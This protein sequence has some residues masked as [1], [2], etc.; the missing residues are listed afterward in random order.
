[1]PHQDQGRSVGAPAVQAALDWLV[2][3]GMFGGLSFRK[4]CRWKPEALVQAA[5]VWAWSEETSL[6]DRFFT[7]QQVIAPS[8]GEQ[9]E[10][11]SYQAFVKLL[12]RHAARLLRALI[13]ALQRQMQ[14]KLSDHYR[15]AGYLAF[16]VD[17]TRIDVPRTAANEQAFAAARCRTRRR[18]RRRKADLKKAAAP[19]I[20]LTTLWH[21]GSGLPWSWRRSSSST[22]ER[23]HAL[24]MLP[25]LPER[26]LIVADAGFVG[27]D[28]WHALREAGHDF[29]IRVGANVTLL[30]QL[31][32]YRECDRRVYLWPDR[33]AQRR[34]PPL[35]LRLAVAHDGKRPVHLVTS[36]LSSKGLSD[37]RLLE[38]Y[39]SR[40]GVEVF[41]RSFKRS[42]GRH[43]L[44]SA[45]P[46]N[47]KL[48]LDWSL[49]A[50]WAACLY[51]K[52]Q[53]L[54]AG[55]EI[56]RTSVA[57]VLRV[58]RRAVRRTEL[59]VAELLAHALI[60]L[61]QRADRTSRNYPRKKTD[62]PGAAPPL[63]LKATN[64]QARLAREIKG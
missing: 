40:W 59:D 60:D 19:R 15:V 30:K 25:Q 2:T 6:V 7:A 18:G 52:C 55:E 53:Q 11:V 50:L 34:Q 35:V 54:D 64:A 31:G 56:A 62:A 47:A 37:R 17:G 23:A 48:E 42:F 45:S 20:S 22:G 3:P 44:R 39:R 61:Y 24:E 1:M 9:R 36:V 5:L 33:R 41:Y 43:K 4:E 32:Y 21:L 51:A 12:R 63:I 29:V 13:A 26:S 10:S 49:A 8:G 14:Q 57:G 58:L 16:G 38:L 28:F 27:Y 46:D